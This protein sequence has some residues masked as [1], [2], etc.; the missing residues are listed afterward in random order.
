M[1]GLRFMKKIILVTL[2]VGAMFGL[3]ERN[4]YSSET[5][6]GSL[7]FIGNVFY[8]DMSYTLLGA[9]EYDVLGTITFADK[10]IIPDFL[11]IG[12]QTDDLACTFDFSNSDTILGDYKNGR[13]TAAITFHIEVEEAD[14]YDAKGEHI[15][16]TLN[17]S[18]WGKVVTPVI[19][20]GVADVRISSK[21]K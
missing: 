17:I 7:K 4:I 9:A 2:F 3:F 16:N 15:L 18:C 19:S 21:K 14:M 10:T 6:Y 5:Y 1:E 12:V 13:L 11:H 8:G 20:F